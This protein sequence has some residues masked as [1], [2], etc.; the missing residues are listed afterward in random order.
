MIYNLE[1][2]QQ[3]TSKLKFFDSPK[4]LE[5][6]ISKYKLVKT[7]LGKP[8]LVDK[9]SLDVLVYNISISHKEN[10]L[11]S[12]IGDN[13]LGCDIEKIADCKYRAL[14]LTDEE[15][16]MLVKS[17]EKDKLFTK[18]WTL[19]EAIL[20]SAGIGFTKGLDA[21][22][23]NSIGDDEVIFSTDL[24]CVESLVLKEFVMFEIEDFI[25]SVVSS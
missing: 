11:I 5:E 10:Y 16:L 14:Y 8:Y 13:N 19:K 3:L 18:I 1:K 9:D 25:I 24:Y 6:S 23:I 4:E 7:K 22:S 2:N 15:K 17:Q 12:I 21:I 20:K